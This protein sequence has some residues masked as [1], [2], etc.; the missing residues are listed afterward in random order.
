MASLS[1]RRPDPTKGG[2]SVRGALANDLSF[3][4]RSAASAPSKPA[5]KTRGGSSEDPLAGPLRR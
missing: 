5:V 3:V 2:P 1:K 4:K